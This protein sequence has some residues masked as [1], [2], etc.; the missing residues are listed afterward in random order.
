VSEHTWCTSF[1]HYQTVKASVP[2]ADKLTWILALHHQDTE[3]LLQ[4]LGYSPAQIQSLVQG[5]VVNA[6]K[7]LQA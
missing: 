1:I 3:A 2:T 4:E 6:I 5:G 7:P